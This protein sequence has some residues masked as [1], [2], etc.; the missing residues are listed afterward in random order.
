MLLRVRSNVGVW[1]VDGLDEATA[2]VADLK[3]GIA[4]TRPHVVYTQ[5][6]SADPAG[7]QV[8]DENKTLKE[9]GLA[10]HGN[11]VHC[12]V[13]PSTCVETAPAG[14]VSAST[15]ASVSASGAS[16]APGSS[17]SLVSDGPMRR[18]IDKDG[19]IR[20]VPSS[21]LPSGKADKGFRK[22]MMALRDMKMN[23]TLA[24]FVALDSQFEFKIKRQ[25]TAICQQ[26]SLDVASINDFQAYCQRFQFKRKRMAFLYGKFVD[27]PKGEN[28][29]DKEEG[30]SENKPKTIVEAIYEPPQEIDS[31]A[32]EGIVLTEDPRE[33]TVERMAE[34]LGLKKVG[35]IF[36]HEPRE[37]GYV[38]SNAEVLMAAEYQL[39]SAQGVNETPFVTIKVTQ[40]ADGLV[41]VE[42]FQVSQQC[43]TMVAEQALEISPD[44]P[45]V[46]QVNE[47]F[48]AIQEGKE[49]K[50]VEN[51]FFL[52]VVP[53]V[54][55]TSDV[56]VADFPKLNRDLDDRVPNHDAL[57]RELSKAGTAGWTLED[58]LADLNLLLYLSD[59]LDKE[60]DLPRI[61]TSIVNREIPL[62]DGY[63]L[64]IK[65]LAG[66]DG[67]F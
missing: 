14:E 25:E 23:W 67:A 21:E 54:Q 38:M 42:A 56:F 31:T 52:T 43:L 20:L 15:D 35:W 22:G 49:S 45:K 37:K 62:D 1:R 44:N 19:R 24:D 59:Y 4:Q 12:R 55:H 40:G 48:T 9:Q 58:R 57:K 3:R 64:I 30:N 66:L 36:C 18:I 33:E 41:S 11:M 17:S 47:T 65:S 29:K 26:V 2:T 7:K 27:E 16:A 8:I 39:E 32:A 61:C 63:K 28:D 50:T 6:F 46:C 34:W 60:N 51:N 13:D 5:D 10:Q 53:I